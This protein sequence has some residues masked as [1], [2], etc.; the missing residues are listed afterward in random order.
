MS[1]MI[2]KPGSPPGMLSWFDPRRRDLGTFAFILNRV[3][4]LG[5]TLYLFLHLIMLGNLARGPEA[6]DRFLN[7]IEHP[8]FVFGEYLVV[9]AGLIHGF[10]GIRVALTSFG[11][12]VPYQKRF[13]VVMMVIALVAGVI[14][15]VRMFAEVK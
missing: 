10:N 6:Y 11:I 2:Q 1:D 9:L 4:A 3:T 15:G 13:F 14:F 5:L 12:G 7:T 8:V